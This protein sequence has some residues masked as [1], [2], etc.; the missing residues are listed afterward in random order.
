MIHSAPQGRPFPLG[1]IVCAAF[2]LVLLAACFMADAL[3]AEPLRSRAER[4]MNASLKGYTVRITKVRP[5]IWRMG[6]DVLDLEVIQTA[7]PDPPVADIGALD[8]SLVWRELIHFRLAGNLVVQ[9]PALHI[10]LPQIQ[11]EARSHVRLRDRGW[12]KALESVYPI[13]LD[14]V[15]V[16]DGSLLYLSSRTARG[17]LQ[18]T[19]VN[20]VATN[21]RNIAAVRGTFPSPVTLEGDLFDTGKVRFKGAADFLR[22]P[23]IAARGE[24]HLDHVPLD[25]LAPFASDYMLKATGGILS[26][27]G[28]ME[29]TPEAR[30]IHLADVRVEDLRVDYITSK[31]TQALEQAQAEQAVK[32]AQSVRNAR[33][34]L[35]QVD[36][37]R[38]TRSQFG[39]V[40]ETTRPPYRLFIS[41]VSLDLE[42]LSNQTLLGRSRFHG[43]GTFMGDGATV[44]SG[45]FQPGADPMDFDVHLHLDDAR[46][47]D[48][49]DCLMAHAGVDVAAGLVSI[50]AEIAVKDHKV[51]GYLKPMLKNVQFYDRGKDRSKP[52]R[53]RV[54]LHLLQIL[55]KVFKNHSTQEVA[56]VATL[57]GSTR[58]PKAGEW[59]AIR[60]LIGN[61]L[62]HAVLPGFQ[63][64]LLK[65][66]Q[67]LPGHGAPAL[68]PGPVGADDR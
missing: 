10:D 25:R 43:Q 66:R 45:G 15:K 6:I 4:M 37:L 60:K 44:L 19:K 49:N 7:H 38:L 58:Q 68:Q 52:F 26:L 18:F 17:P 42:N 31:A 3:L 33:K 16:L 57:S 59:E 46:L 20:L 27:D 65:P 32:L 61:G 5:H 39:F 24:V 9:H 14:R 53:K 55:A 41:D 63:D 34:L 29:D 67:D 8:L 28:I 62:W 51:D 35:L 36:T 22:E 50:Y 47:A 12:Q 48:L 13:K 40:N 23:V 1:R 21:V 30:V 11:E 54:E 64:P 2:G 56:T